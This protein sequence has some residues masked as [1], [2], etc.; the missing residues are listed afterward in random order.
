MVAMAKRD[1]EACLN[2]RHLRHVR[3]CRCL[4][5]SDFWDIANHDRSPPAILPQ[6]IVVRPVPPRKFFR[7][8]P[9]DRRSLLPWM[10]HLNNSMSLN[11][12]APFPTTPSC[13]ATSNNTHRTPNEPGNHC[14][15]C[16]HH[17]SRQSIIPSCTG[18]TTK[19]SRGGSPKHDQYP[20]PEHNQC[21]PSSVRWW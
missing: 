1:N 6:Q 7:G 2:S 4:D 21:D 16:D 9:L 15:Q 11:N 18:F 14:N 8:L 3:H 10:S 12:A 17:S 5:V 13:A 20:L 19:D